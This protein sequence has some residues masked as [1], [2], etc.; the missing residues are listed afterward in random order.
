[1]KDYIFRSSVH[2]VKVS[3]RPDYGMFC[4]SHNLNPNFVHAACIEND[5]MIWREYACHWPLLFIYKFQENNE[6]RWISRGT[7]LNILLQSAS[8][9]D[10]LSGAQF[11]LVVLKCVKHAKCLY[12][13]CMQCTLFTSDQN[14]R[15]SCWCCWAL[16]SQF[17]TSK[18]WMKKK[19]EPIRK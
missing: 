17:A 19:T 15:T 1:M 18:M 16:T 2:T 14:D 7:G 4:A 9:L 6:S 12:M 13:Q 8:Q 5:I 10:A 11:Y 3:L